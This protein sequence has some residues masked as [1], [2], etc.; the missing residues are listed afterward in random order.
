M[1][2]VNHDGAGHSSSAEP[3]E[4]L[5]LSLRLKAQSKLTSTGAAG[6]ASIAET[7]SIHSTRGDQ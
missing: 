5:G 4:S 1:R 3:V 7:T 6:K 2:P